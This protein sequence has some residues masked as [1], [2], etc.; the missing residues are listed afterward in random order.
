MKNV[1]VP[2]ISVVVTNY[3]YGQYLQEAIDSVLNQTYP[4]IKLYIIDDASTDNSH[5]LLKQYT[6]K[7]VIIKHNK[8]KGIVYA[9]N[10][11]FDLCNTKYILF[12]D[13]DD[14]LDTDYVKTLF[15]AAEKHDLDV[16]YCD[17]NYFISHKAD[18]GQS[19]NPPDFNIDRMKNGNFVHMSS[20]MRVKAIGATRFDKA[21]EKI[22]HE[23]WDFFLNLALKRVKFGKVNGVA[24]NY[25]VK[26]INRNM[27]LDDEIGF[28]NLYTFIYEKYRLLYP[29]DINYLAYY[30]FAKRFLRVGVELQEARRVIDEEVGRVGILQSRLNDIL[31]SRSYKLG[32]FL[33]LPLRITKRIIR[34]A[35]SFEYKKATYSI[36]V[37]S[38]LYQKIDKSRF[39]NRNKNALTENHIQKK[40]GDFQKKS[41]YAVVLHLYYVSNWEEVFVHK[42]KRLFSSLPFDLYITMP[43]KNLS[44]VSVIRESFPDANVIIVP[45]RGRDVLPFI[46]TALILKE[47]G[48]KKVLKLHSKKS[49][50]RNHERNTAETGIDWLINTL[51]ALIPDDPNLMV[52]MVSKLNSKQTGMIGAFEYL[53]PLKMYL[54]NNRRLI[55]QIISSLGY[56]LFQN[57][58]SQELEKYTYFGGTM[59]WVD[60]AS[61]ER[62]LHISKENFQP[63]KSQTDATIAH[64]LER[65][66]CILPTLE[67]KDVYAVSDK[68]I[69]VGLKKTTY[70][71]WYFDDISD[72]HPPISIV[73][74]VY[75]DWSSLSLNIASLKK[76]VGNHEGVSVH[77]VNDCGP[78][79]DILEKRII[80]NI[81]GI[82]NFFY[83]RNEK[84]LG[85]VKTCN[86]AVFEI[87][88]QED[89]VL[90][91]NSDTKVTKNFV[92]EMRRVLYSESK[93][94]AVT[95]RSNNATIWS[96]PMT[97]KFAHH[98]TASYALYRAIKRDLPDKYITPTIHGFC[99]LIRR[100]VVKLYGLFDEV[101]GRGYGEE[102][103][104]AM[105]IG[106]QGWK[107]A[108]ANYSYVFHY[109]S[110]SFG[111]EARNRQIEANEKILLKRYP[112]YRKLVQEYWDSI[113]EPMK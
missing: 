55:E 19:L 101:Y 49:L 81:E 110:R 28:A 1:S 26:S 36:V 94:G 78:E 10:E 42:L 16:A 51:N 50:H 104:F 43:E 84:N 21:M 74:P 83:H 108:V 85:F 24:L 96:V 39:V 45:N 66:F 35:K 87:V 99:V 91:L 11:A 13:A 22:T 111:N 47:A 60:L 4:A 63:E 17:A 79:A 18:M 20:L 7:A 73:V 44:H 80:D 65:V 30:D 41:D 75:S 31:G 38:E 14:W 95:S 106:S 62:A 33:F 76:Y 90:L 34:K 58:I 102:N 67:H 109:E 40:D 53:Y 64:A 82:T 107:C 103:D 98:R 12:L 54:K 59:F 71:G 77:Y 70:P 92:Y 32:K 23:D 72:G 52:E 97:A 8:N 61:I 3:N 27:H 9:R 93:I 6:D 46:K 25:R 57:N 86:R 29:E 56:D 89:D 112:N 48:Y 88:N 105:R 69:K 37:N 5:Q 100:E 15:E 68:I 2:E 113:K